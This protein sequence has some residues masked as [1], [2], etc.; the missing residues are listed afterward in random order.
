MRSIEEV[1]A[2]A[3]G[4]LSRAAHERLLADDPRDHAPKWHVYGLLGHMYAVIEAAKRI[5]QRLE[6]DFDLV[7]L[8]ALHDIGKIK[9]FPEACRLVDA[10]QGTNRL[11][12]GH[13]NRSAGYALKVLCLPGDDVAAIK[14]HG[15]AYQA[16]PETIAQHLGSEGAFLKWMLLSAADAVGFGWTEAQKAG[17]PKTAERFEEAASLLGAMPDSRALQVACDAV[18]TWQPV[19]PLEFTLLAEVGLFFAITK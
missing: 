7:R 16:R 4:A 8:S 5:E 13:E 12:V 9:Q 6:L 17:R 2:Y 3:S 18:R 14:W 11:Y 15:L 1:V 19:D 10:G